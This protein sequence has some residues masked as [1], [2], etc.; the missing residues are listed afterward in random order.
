[1]VSGQTIAIAGA[2]SIG[3]FVGGMLAAGGHRVALLARPRIIAEIEA[4]GLRPTSFEGFD[5]TVASDRFV[6]SENPSVFETACIV[7]VTVKSADTADMADVIAK[8]APSDAVIV[9]LQNGVGNKAVLRE[10][11]PGRRVLGGM[12]P[13]NVIALGDG[14]FHRAT[15]GD[16]VIERD[17]TRTAEKLSVPGLKMR[18]TD[19]I[20]GVQW[21]KLVLN[22][23]N[24]LNALADLPLRRQIGL[25]PW[26][27]LF[28]DQVAEALAA[29]AADG[30]KP[31]SSTP[32]PLAWLPSLLCL[33]D[34]IF[35][36]LLGRTMKIDP[37]ARSS[38]WE[39]L[40]HGRRT[41][42]DYLQ[43]VITEIAARRDLE[44]PL[45]RRIAE[46][47]RQAER[48]GKG[49]PGLTPEQVRAR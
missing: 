19:N 1:M 41:E 20:E 40:K 9:S 3:C 32:I 29:I 27:R 13:F 7:L 42:I 26:R 17:E 16:I 4:S 36:M 34:F 2:G 33:P 28:A 30:I 6:L 35:E 18:A 31:V 21:G 23:N 22:L 11:L 37:E 38:M 10:R 25:R 43:G 49:S 14:R 39:D 5:Q 47:I 15:S 46:L 8:N 24:A 45:S 48:E 12:V 44:A